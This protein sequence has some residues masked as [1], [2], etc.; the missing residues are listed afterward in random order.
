MTRGMSEIGVQPDRIDDRLFR[1]G[2]T[3]V[4]WAVL[5]LYLLL[6]AF[7]VMDVGRLALAVTAGALFLENLAFTWQRALKAQ[8]DRWFLTLVRHADIV[9]VSGVIVALRDVTTP[10]WALYFVSMV[11]AAHLVTRRQMVSFALWCMVNYVS[12]AAALNVLG[13]DVPWGYVTVVSFLIGFLGLNAMLVADGEER[14]RSLIAQVAVTD[15]LTG[16]PNRRLFHDTYRECL[17]DAIERRLTL[18]LMLVD[19]DHF[20]EINDRDGHPAGDDKLREV[21]RALSA[22]VRRGDLVARYGGDEFVVVA[23]GT[24]RSDAMHLAERLRAAA[25]ERGASVSVGVALFP[26]DAENEDCLVAAADAALYRA[27]QAGRN[28]VRDALA[29]A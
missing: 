12:A 8:P 4:R 22:V 10:I 21:S 6:V 15:T 18:A 14:L 29:A 3:A 13:E 27:K 1:R 28:C 2:L 7:G 20:K 19:V 16:L 24:V 25:V 17:R 9:I 23:P 11:A 26:E 5:V